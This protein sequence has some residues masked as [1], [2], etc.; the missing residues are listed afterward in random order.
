L[1]QFGTLGAKIN[2]LTEKAKTGARSG[3]EHSAAGNAL[4]MGDRQHRLKRITDQNRLGNRLGNRFAGTKLGQSMRFG[5]AMGRRVAV[6]EAAEDK[7]EAED[8]AA[9]QARITRAPGYLTQKDADLETSM[10]AA[11][12]KGDNVNA[13][14]YSNLLTAKGGPGISAV[15]AGLSK[16]QSKGVDV[17]SVAGNIMSNHAAAYKAKDIETFMW[18]ATG[19]TETLSGYASRHKDTTGQALSS[20]EIANT[21]SATLDRLDKAGALDAGKISEL[22]S[23]ENLKGKLDTKQRAVLDKY[24]STQPSSSNTAPAPSTISTSNSS[25]SEII[26][27]ASAGAS[28]DELRKQAGKQ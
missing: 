26:T 3:F 1:N 19:G 6:A 18:A 24:V 13:I 17:S 14:A 9:A 12:E 2:G 16:A 4:A 8:I 10:I 7:L 27:G 23:N 21:S 11:L 28:I 5:D 25:G 15:N 22:Y 20:E